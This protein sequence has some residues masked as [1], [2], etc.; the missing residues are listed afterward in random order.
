MILNQPGQTFML[1]RSCFYIGQEI[2]ANDESCYAGLPGIITEIR[3]GEDKETENPTVDIYCDFYLPENSSFFLVREL[4]ARFKAPLV[5]ICFG[6]VIMAPEMIEP[7]TQYQINPANIQ[8]FALYYYADCHNDNSAG[9][10][11]VS[12]DLVLLR[13]EMQRQIKKNEYF[14]HGD[15]VS[16]DGY[17]ISEESFEDSSSYWRAESDD[18]FISYSIEPV[19]FL[20]SEL[21]ENGGEA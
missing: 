2:V 6:Q 21:W 4:E 18:N 9:M 13:A 1:E 15:D 10:L 11:C 3:D 19:V 17:S 7:K 8:L 14:R 12:H 20:L 16:F 5:D